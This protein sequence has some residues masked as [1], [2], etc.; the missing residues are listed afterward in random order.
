MTKSRLVR[1]ILPSVLIFIFV[2]A[3]ALTVLSTATARAATTT[4]TPSA[5]ATTTPEV[6]AGNEIVGLLI[7]TAFAAAGYYVAKWIRRERRP[8]PPG[9]WWGGFGN[10]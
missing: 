6:R 4:P 3:I 10:R 7:L 1:S 9:P 2:V 5:S 8:R